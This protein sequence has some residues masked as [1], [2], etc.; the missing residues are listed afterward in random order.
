MATIVAGV[1]GCKAG[2]FVVLWNVDENTF[3][4]RIVPDI[5][6]VRTFA[7]TA[8]VIAVDIPIGLLDHAVPGGR[9]CD[10]LARKMLGPK[11]ASSVFSPPVRAALECAAYADALKANRNSSDSALGISKQ[12][13][14]IMPKIRE[15]DRFMTPDRQQS[16]FEVHP[17]LCFLG[18]NNGLP[19]SLGKRTPEGMTARKALLFSN[20]FSDIVTH[21]INSRI[22]AVAKDDILDAC[23]ACWTA[24]RIAL[25]VATPISGVSPLDS[26]GLRMEMWY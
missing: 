6:A 7:S 18:M 21:A 2:W 11:R 26:R 3:T 22:A 20:G 23:A 19:M 17:E 8:Q 24:R 16:V 12:C 4:Y 5:W 13:F 15:V 25:S 14:A 9:A 10:N 1:D